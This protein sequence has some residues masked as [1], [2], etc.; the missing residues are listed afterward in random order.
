MMIHGR[1]KKGWPD[2]GGLR[3]GMKAA[4]EKVY[5]EQRDS[6]YGYLLYMTKDEQLAQDLAQETFL[7]IFL[8]LH[9][10]KGESSEKTWCIA[11]ARNTYFSWKRKKRPVLVEEKY[12]AEVA[13]ETQIPE[14]MLL[15]KEENDMIRQ[16][17]FDMQEGQRQILL[18]RDYEKFSYK[19][20]GEILGISEIIVKSRIH[21]ARECY[22]EKYRKLLAEREVE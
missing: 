19:E 15:K 17:L 16:V 1:E 18:L 4:F 13:D 11:I 20:I 5:R 12:G 22:R 10:F 7:K 21:R 8:N 6:V 2:D 9:R 3:E 14:E